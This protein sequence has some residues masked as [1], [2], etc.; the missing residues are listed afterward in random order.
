[1]SVFL[2]ADWSRLGFDGAPLPGDP[3]VLQGIIDDFTYLRDTAWSVSQG[4]DAFASASS[5]GFGGDTANVLR[6][7]ISG[8]LKT[9]VYNLARAFSLAGEAVA[10]YRLALME[11]QQTAAGVVSQAAELTAGDPKL[12]GLKQQV[13]D[14]VGQVNAAAR[15]MEQVLRD[16]SEMVSQ[17]IEVPSLSERIWKGVE[18]ALEITGMVLILLS[19]V[20]DGPLGVIGFGMGV[21]AFGMNA[22]D[23][24]E[25]REKWQ[26]LALAS[27]GF[28]LPETRGLF[29]AG[30]LGAATRALLGNTGHAAA[31]MANVL[32]SPVKFAEFMAQTGASTWRGVV[33]LPGMLTKTPEVLGSAWE[34]ASA[35]VG[36]DVGRVMKW[37][38][39]LVAGVGAHTA[40]GLTNLGRAGAALLTPM[41]FG[42]MATLGFREA[43]AAM[44]RRAQLTNLTNAARDFRA[45]WKGYG[46]RAARAGLEVLGMLHAMQGL[47]PRGRP[48]PKDF[49]PDAAA[50]AKTG[51]GVLL[52]GP[53]VWTKDATGKLD[54]PL[55][56]AER[57]WPV[58]VRP[59]GFSTVGWPDE[60]S[61]PAFSRL[62]LPGQ[63]DRQAAQ[64]PDWLRVAGLGAGRRPGLLE[65]LFRPASFM[66]T[67]AGVPV[68]T[69]GVPRLEIAPPLRQLMWPGADPSLTGTSSTSDTL[70]HSGGLT[71]G[72]DSAEG[73][74]TPHLEVS[75][76]L[77]L[78]RAGAPDPS[79]AHLPAPHL[80][81]ETESPSRV[82]SAGNSEQTL[83]PAQPRTVARHP[84]LRLLS[85]IES[86]GYDV[87]KVADRLGATPGELVD[88][89]TGQLLSADLSEALDVAAQRTGEA[90]AG[91]GSGV[92]PEHFGALLAL[93]KNSGHDRARLASHF[94]R[95]E[96]T[97]RNWLYQ[98]PESGRTVFETLD[99]HFGLGL[100]EPVPLRGEGIGELLDG[101][102]VWAIR[103]PQT[104]RDFEILGD[105]RLSIKPVGGAGQPS[106]GFTVTDLAN[107]VFFF[108]VGLENTTSAA[109]LVHAD[110]TLTGT[111][112]VT[113]AGEAQRVAVLR[114]PL[115][116]R[117][118]APRLLDTEGEPMTAWPAN[119]MRDGRVAL[120]PH[121]APLASP[122][123]LM[124]D[125]ADSRVL[126]QTLCAH[127]DAC[128]PYWQIDYAAE[129]ASAVRLDETG[130]PTGQAA[131]VHFGPDG[132]LR[133]V[134]E[135]GEAVLQRPL[136][137]ALHGRWQPTNDFR[138]LELPG[139][140][141]ALLRFSTGGERVV[142]FRDAELVDA[143]GHFL[144]GA[145]L[146]A[147][148][149]RSGF[150]VRLPVPD[151]D[152]MAAWHLDNYG[153][154]REREVPVTGPDL[155]AAV[156]IS[157][158]YAHPR[159][160]S[161]EVRFCRDG[162][163]TPTRRFSA[164]P[165][166]Q[167]LAAQHPDGIALTFTPTGW[168]FHLDGMGQ[169]I[170]DDG[171]PAPT[172]T[173]ANSLPPAHHARAAR[174]RLA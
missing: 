39:D 101:A 24:A 49:L 61:T 34:S 120:R 139:S 5:E 23:F 173:G 126:K 155:P 102:T 50:G 18:M 94:D 162:S 10:E 125:P 144:P 54:E 87:G 66:N 140:G 95:S 133:L 37:Y 152:E 92:L 17:P 122:V 13:Q 76:I 98:W 167:E 90:A 22:V 117:N 83:A 75:Q 132:M 71:A 80:T 33:A 36:R 35:A 159:K 82:I 137:D 2:D 103:H 59:D 109:T 161:Y 114:L 19:S 51:P 85:L 105:T 46:Q 96:A 81:Q 40:Y 88:T 118:R 44:R 69:Q 166:P 123:R 70:A 27:L 138:T 149:E 129:P 53:V 58:R 86:E 107:G 14:Q 116:G 143:D 156:R 41:T 164:G 172:T 6:G 52:P 73:L 146:L 145:R 32:S 57:G 119:A 43:W 42:E 21:A 168:T 142:D 20:V 106:D 158:V 63:A 130:R 135:S 74:P 30:E 8:R 160:P 104:G 154:L 100:V 121:D 93:Y 174:L 9:F 38:P 153:A 1:M 136:T 56:A 25:G 89:L 64:I 147:H 29:T 77:E 45:G 150:T 65:T 4:L 55:L 170:G 31:K 108:R 3:R 62:W 11:G 128:G 28:L 60:S 12:A 134:A 16:A 91:S 113:G 47:R 97:V 131:S 115:E 148:K 165:L 7:V 124:I 67:A 48:G 127:A 68:R 157:I 72:Q 163:S 169:I 99:G 79:A 112:S 78:L 110:L 111:E 15:T 171:T 151:T 26:S 84:Y 141:G